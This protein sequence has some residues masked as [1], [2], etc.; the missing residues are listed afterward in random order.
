M[1]LCNRL[2]SFLLSKKVNLE[3]R[4]IIESRQI[5]QHHTMATPIQFYLHHIPSR[6]RLGRDNRRVATGQ[7]I[8]ETTFPSI[9]RANQNDPPTIRVRRTLCELLPNSF[10]RFQ[11]ALKSSQRISASD[12][13]DILVHKIEPRF[14]IRQ[15]TK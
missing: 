3:A 1:G 5:H 8:E 2:L 4:C 11:M 15:E 6:S 13:L 7:R 12:K 14:N 10:D 9:R